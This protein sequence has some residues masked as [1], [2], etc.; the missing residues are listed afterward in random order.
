[1]AFTYDNTLP[2]P[3]DQLRNAIQDTDPDYYDF[4]DEEIL[5]LYAISGEKFYA[6]SAELVLRL[7][8]KYSSE[9]TKVE[10]DGVRIDN[11]K[12]GD[13]YY[14]LYKEYIKLAEKEKLFSSKKG[15]A[16]RFTGIN[17]DE[18]NSVREDRTRVRPRFTRDEITFSRRHPE[19]TPINYEDDY[20][21]GF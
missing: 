12:R 13:N 15:A 2:T 20:N 8:I 11:P 9:S 18:F 7:S 4:E 16:I 1:M 14:N 10:V 21:G 5:A 6:T 19:N 17:R 3:L